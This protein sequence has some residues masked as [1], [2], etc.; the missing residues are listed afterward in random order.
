MSNLVAHPPREVCPVCEA[1][2]AIRARQRC[3]RCQWK[4]H[5]RCLGCGALVAPSV[6]HHCASRYV[7]IAT[8]LDSEAMRRQYPQLVEELA[9]YGVHAGEELR[10]V[11]MPLPD[12][13]G[14]PGVTVF[15]RGTTN[16][17][18]P[19]MIRLRN[20]CNRWLDAFELFAASHS[21]AVPLPDGDTGDCVSCGEPISTGNVCPTCASE[22]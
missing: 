11:G 8:P 6:E 18:Q 3:D 13:K 17:D 21:V 4:G 14:T 22:G 10:I 5:S 16:L 9:Y 2:V 1:S 12:G 15:A 7:T 19:D 20:F